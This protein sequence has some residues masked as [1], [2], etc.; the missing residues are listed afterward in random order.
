MAEVEIKL[1]VPDAALPAVRCAVRRGRCAITRLRAIYA[2]TP[3]ARLAAAGWVLRLRQEGRVWVQAI[4]GPGDGALA[5]FEHEVT[6]GAR[7][8][9][10]AF[11]VARH[12][13][14]PGLDAFL[15]ALGD[16]APRL[17]PVF[18]TD[19]HRTHR[20][21]RV[22]GAAVEIALDEG[23][24]LAGGRS[25][26]VCEL[27]FELKAGG[28]APLTRLAAQWARRHGL[29][30]DVQTK[31]ERGARLARGQT[32]AAP[33]YAQTPRLASVMPPDAA[34]RVCVRTVLVQ[35]LRNAAAI[36]SGHAGAEHVHQVRVGLRRL[37]SL[38][39]E[40][41]AWSP[42]FDAALLDA[43]AHWF[44][45]L[46]GTRDVD[47]LAESLLPRLQADG[48]PPLNLRA[49]LALASGDD[50]VA[51][52]R[53]GQTT[54]G[55]LALLA[56]AHDAPAEEA[57]ADLRALAAPA[58]ARLHRRLR[59]AGKTFEALDDEA[60]HR[61]RKQLKRLRYAAECLV[62]L[63]PEKAWLAY[64]RRLKTAQDALGHFQDLCVARELFEAMRPPEPAAWFA[65]G[66]IA[67]RRRECIVQARQALCAL[68]PKPGFL[69]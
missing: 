28:V 17:A 58:L 43:P 45:Q 15:R 61:A 46:G 57:P 14:A 69:R 16:G 18:E 62:D 64:L 9:V 1:Q 54:C 44:K 49:S 4:K 55:L 41:G 37:F 51:L 65:L 52:F 66:W 6:L 32:V 33:T 47:A 5:R 20:L 10:P 27:E 39:R 67:A 12:A 25:T 30:L 38:Q 7:R 8:E 3:D 56:F 31:A 42:A 29:W 68:G 23:A 11:D 36:A 19:V 59:R 21:V 35:V 50:P 2:D 34:L 63:W 13:D 40:F 26:P 53:D 22:R 24:I 60:R 48:A